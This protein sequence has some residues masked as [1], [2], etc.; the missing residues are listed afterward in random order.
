MTADTY[1]SMPH[2][3]N[4]LADRISKN[5]T[6]IAVGGQ[7]RIAA[8]HAELRPRFSEAS[9]ADVSFRADVRPAISHDPGG[10]WSAR[11]LSAESPSRMVLNEGRKR[12]KLTLM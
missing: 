4:T 8:T 12:G 2:E 5:G 1:N 10:S 3:L 6:R 11:W 9:F 7:Q